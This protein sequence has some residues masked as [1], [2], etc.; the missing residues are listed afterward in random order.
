M[1]R[2]IK[3][4]ELKVIELEYV[5]DVIDEHFIRN[6]KTNDLC[7]R[8]ITNKDKTKADIITALQNCDDFKFEIVKT[9]FDTTVE[10]TT[11][12]IEVESD[13]D[14]EIRKQKKAKSNKLAADKRK[15]EKYLKDKLEYERLKKIYG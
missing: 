11:Y 6:S 13:Q 7:K 1:E 5:M 4:I 15:A 2:K 9:R 8:I 14:L 10:L 3:Y 12:K